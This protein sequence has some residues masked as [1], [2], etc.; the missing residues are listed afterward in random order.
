MSDR[1]NLLHRVIRRATPRGLRNW[2]RNPRASAR[3]LGTAWRWRRSGAVRLDLGS[4]ITLLCHPESARTFGAF[5]S[6]PDSMAEFAEFRAAAGP[7][8]RLYDVGAHYGFFS[9]ATL[10]LGGPSSRVLALEPSQRA[11]RVLDANLKLAAAGGRALAVRAAA[12]P[13]DG[14][15]AMIAGGIASEN[16]MF[17]ATGNR[18][19]TVAVPQYSLPGM[20]RLCGWIPTHLKLDIEGFEYEVL[21][22]AE[23]LAALASW[24]P[25][26]FLELHCDFIR[27]RG[28][29]PGD[30]L[31]ALAGRGYRSL[32]HHGSHA[33]PGDILTRP[34]ARLRLTYA[35]DG[36]A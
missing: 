20:E 12:G 10:A 4:G 8:S 35:A 22:A 2:M 15:L 13:R 21:T 6:D 3:W 31:R 5:R 16:Y 9:L 32:S 14:T 24:R 33:A 23:N 27:Q 30:V 36:L 17:A 1:E 25:T 34:L 7:G 19:D 26:L 11:C 29:D 28:F 18:P